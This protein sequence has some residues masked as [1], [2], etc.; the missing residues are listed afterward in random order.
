MCCM[1]PGT[2]LCRLPT[3]TDNLWRADTAQIWQTTMCKFELCTRS[4]GLAL[5]TLRPPLTTS[6]WLRSL[7]VLS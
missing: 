4:E 5:W 3:P 1:I 6:A 7:A 2:Q